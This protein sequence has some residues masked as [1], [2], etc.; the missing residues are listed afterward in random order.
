MCAAD[1][2][3]LVLQKYVVHCEGSL[4]MYGSAQ[5]R[6]QKGGLGV[7]TPPE[8]FSMQHVSN[9]FCCFQQ[10][11]LLPEIHNPPRKKFLGTAVI[12]TIDNAR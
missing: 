12:E 6:T 11:Y 8:I 5:G 9:T 4:L 10:N 2:V 3:A 1:E 7:Q